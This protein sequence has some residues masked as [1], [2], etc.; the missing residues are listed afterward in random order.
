M[1]GRFS[2]EECTVLSSKML[3]FPMIKSGLWWCLVMG[4]DAADSHTVGY[5]LIL[6]VM[7]LWSLLWNTG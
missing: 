5:A 7:A 3:R 4:W 6:Q 1:F 2:M